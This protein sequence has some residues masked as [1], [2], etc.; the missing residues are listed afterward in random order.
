[1][2]YVTAVHFVLIVMIGTII[3]VLVLNTENIAHSAPKGFNSN[4]A[5]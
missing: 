4:L 3:I 1:M 5:T 2:L